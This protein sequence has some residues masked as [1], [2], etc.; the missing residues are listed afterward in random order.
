MFHLFSVNLFHV[1][2]YTDLGTP[3][4]RN[5]QQPKFPTTF[6]SPTSAP[7]P[8][9]IPSEQRPKFSFTIKT[10]T[11]LGK[12]QNEK[13]TPQDGQLKAE[14]S[15][16]HVSKMATEHEESKSTKKSSDVSQDS[17]SKV[18]NKDVKEKGATT[19]NDL[20]SP[21]PVLVSFPVKKDEK[22]ES[23]S[24]NIRPPQLFIPR[25]VHA[26]SSSTDTKSNGK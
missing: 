2:V 10:Q 3:L 6:T 11:K 16:K 5:A 25:S 14:S 24:K 20:K 9:L 13:K 19:S 17:V 15:P 12:T 26:K 18:P 7:K 4:S 21:E 1:I 22:C 8:S 23:P